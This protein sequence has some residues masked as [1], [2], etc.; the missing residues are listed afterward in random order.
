MSRSYVRGRD[1]GKNRL[2]DDRGS[3]SNPGVR[4]GLRLRSLDYRSGL[5]KGRVEENRTFD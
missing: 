1:K 2:D 3:E 4:L 5:T